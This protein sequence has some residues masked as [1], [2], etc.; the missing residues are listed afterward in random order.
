MLTQTDLG[1]EGCGTEEIF[2]TLMVVHIGRYDRPVDGLLY[3]QFLG[4]TYHPINLFLQMK[5]T[6]C[7]S[8]SS[9]DLFRKSDP[10][11]V[12][13]P[14]LHYNQLVKVADAA[15]NM[16]CRVAASQPRTNRVQI[17]FLPSV[18][19]KIKAYLQE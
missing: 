18:W 14:E 11:C 6:Q 5:S 4:R 16:M 2:G 7:H 8:R 13:H 12:S 9:S 19:I 1:I 17:D 15:C 10:G 3:V